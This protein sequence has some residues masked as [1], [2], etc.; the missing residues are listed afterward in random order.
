M[1]LKGTEFKS[2]TFRTPLRAMD[3]Q[4][5]PQMGFY[6]IGPRV[7]HDYH[8]STHIEPSDAEDYLDKVKNWY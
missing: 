6:H 4:N 5:L 7:A 2:P 8:L 3:H 1:A